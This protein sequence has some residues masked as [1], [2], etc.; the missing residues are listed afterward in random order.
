MPAMLSDPV[1]TKVTLVLR[2]GSVGV[3]E[4]SVEATVC[5][6]IREGVQGVGSGLLRFIFVVVIR[7]HTGNAGLTPPPPGLLMYVMFV[8]FGLIYTNF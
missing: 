5:G 7:Y 8:Y 3:L 2:L 6:L 1:K 4:R